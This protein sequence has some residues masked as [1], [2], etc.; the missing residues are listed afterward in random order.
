MYGAMGMFTL[1]LAVLGFSMAR[2]WSCPKS[3]WLKK[4]KVSRLVIQVP[5]AE[6]G[7]IK[8]YFNIEIAEKMKIFSVLQ[9]RKPSQLTSA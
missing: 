1:L 9:N 8:R 6:H 7:F 5:D 4:P 2:R 3:P